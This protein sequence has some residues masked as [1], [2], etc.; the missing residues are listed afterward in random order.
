MIEMTRR[1][2]NYFVIFWNFFGIPKASAKYVGPKRLGESGIGRRIKRLD[3]QY[4]I[5]LARDNP[6]EM[7]RIERRR[8]NLLYSTKEW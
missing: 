5:A 3:D 7:E 8:K 2:E 4:L 6:R 1:T